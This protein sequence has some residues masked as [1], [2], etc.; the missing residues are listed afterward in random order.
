MII[1]RSINKQVVRHTFLFTM[2]RR[3][4]GIL[5]L[6]YIQSTS[7]NANANSQSLA[8][9]RAFRVRGT[10]STASGHIA[11]H[12]LPRHGRSAN[13]YFCGLLFGT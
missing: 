7:C 1:Q 5:L 3:N 8:Q 11:L 4:L 6:E 9:S 13:A 10:E 12:S 2:S